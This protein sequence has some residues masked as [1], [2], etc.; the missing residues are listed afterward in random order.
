VVYNSERRKERTVKYVRVLQ[1]IAAE[2]FGS[3]GD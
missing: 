1:S 3:V 2:A